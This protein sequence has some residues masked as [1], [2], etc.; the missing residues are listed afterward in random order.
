[1]RRLV[2]VAAAVAMVALAFV[3]RSR[4]DDDSD[5]GNTGDD[6]DGELTLLCDPDL[7]AACEASGLSFIE[8]TSGETATRLR[9]GGDLG[10]DVWV[11]SSAW[12][13]VVESEAA[14]EARSLATSPVVVAA[15]AGDADVATECPT[16][17]DLKCIAD[18]A[19]E[20][21][22]ASG[23]PDRSIGLAVAGHIATALEGDESWALAE[24]TDPAVASTF[25]DIASDDDPF[26]ALVVER[27][28]Y[29]AVIVDEAS[30]NDNAEVTE[31]DPAADISVVAAGPGTGAGELDTLRDALEADGWDPRD[32]EVPESPYG[33]GALAALWLEVPR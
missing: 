30:T 33:E 28:R 12:L 21:N 6:G 2:A 16:T 27:G 13:D 32:G 5:D 19:D 3:V 29:D 20:L 31:A 22:I 1:M 25:A 23:D 24:V 9:D 4:L 8:E 15:L 26:Q 18:A 17:G 11:T 14:L 7:A 10:A